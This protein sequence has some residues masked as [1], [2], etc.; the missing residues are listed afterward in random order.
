MAK[1][2]KLLRNQLKEV[3][4]E[5]APEL[6]LQIQYKELEHKLALRMEVVEKFIK[7]QL[8]AIDE[9]H[10]NTMSYLVRSMSTSIKP[11]NKE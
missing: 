10:R 7:E 8:K 9:N 5:M 3:V 4:K 2:A 6:L 11:E 1:N